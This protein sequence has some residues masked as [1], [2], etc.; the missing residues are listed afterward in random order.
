VGEAGN[1]QTGTALVPK[2]LFLIPIKPLG[3]GFFMVMPWSFGIAETFVA[4]CFPLPTIS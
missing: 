4:V 3:Q 2:T 1:H